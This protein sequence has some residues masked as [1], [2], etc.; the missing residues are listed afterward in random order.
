MTTKTTSATNQLAALEKK[1]QETHTD[2]QKRKRQRDEYNNET[3]AM[4]ADLTARR[5]THPW[6]H[7]TDGTTVKPETETARLVVKVKARMREPYPDQVALDEAVATYQ[8]A[9]RAEHRFKLA[10]KDQ[11]TAEITAPAVE[12]EEQIREGWNLVLRGTSTYRNA[13]D[14]LREFIVHAA[15]LSGQHL[16]VDPAIREWQQQAEAAIDH[17]IL[18]PR[19]SDAGCAAID[20][21]LE[22]MEQS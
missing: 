7:E 3:E 8:A 11:L 18:I 22:A 6:E 1:R 21:A 15:P 5:T 19:I 2:V 16:A 13:Q 14:A 20:H 9:E 10:N 4:R 12:A 17:P